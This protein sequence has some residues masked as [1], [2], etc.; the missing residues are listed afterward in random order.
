[1]DTQSQKP[2]AAGKHPQGL[3][4]LF[5]TEM[6]E[7]FSYYGM[8]ALLVLY[9]VQHLQYSD[10]LAGSIYGAYTG[11]VY[12]TPIIGG[13]VADRWLGYRHSIF[14]GGVL[15]AFGHLSLAFDSESSLFLGLAL[16]VL[17]NGFFKPNIST[18]LGTLYKD[19]PSLKDS[20]FTIFY[21]GINLGAL[22][23]SL[24]C[25][26][27]GENIGWHYGFGLAG[28]GMLLGLAQFHYGIN[29]VQ[30]GSNLQKENLRLSSHPSEDPFNLTPALTDQDKKS[31]SVITILAI[32]T[33]LFWMAF[34]QAGSSINLFTFRYVDRSF[35]LGAFLSLFFIEGTYQTIQIPASVFQSVNPLLILLLAPLVAQLWVYLERKS[36]HIDTVTKFIFSFVF[37]GT[38]FL[39]LAWGSYSID[40]VIT[41]ASIAWVIFAYL[42]HTIGE[43]LISPVGLSM[44]SKLSPPNYLGLLMGVWLLSN[45]I[46]HYSGGLLS[47][48]LTTFGSLSNFFMIFVYT[49]I[50]GFVLLYA[51][52]KYILSLV[53]GRL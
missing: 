29:P 40:G 33:I 48:H 42:F 12:L 35:D 8:R 14:L 1:V 27:I 41:K 37:L 28:I 26:F 50:A 21:M 18:L 38:G 7:R 39:V 43:L 25:G 23:G 9:L 36:I 47:G 10:S 49:S 22:F 6:W 24:L 15:M 30:S 4:V 31:I 19:N 52:K 46:A 32:F 5:F 16:L 2:L 17:G 45:A 11:L 53:P 44:V 51:M 34:E 3:Y 13:Y 20:G